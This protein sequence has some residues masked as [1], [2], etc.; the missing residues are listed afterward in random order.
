LPL[1]FGFTTNGTA[2]VQLDA[3]LAFF[4]LARG[5]YAYAGWGVWGM[6]WPLS[7]ASLPREFWIDYGAP[8]NVCRELEPGVFERDWTNV[9][10]RLDCNRFQARWNFLSSSQEQ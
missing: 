3:D 5:P 6:T 10:I 7:A 1:L 2:L 4:L 8:Q 9:N